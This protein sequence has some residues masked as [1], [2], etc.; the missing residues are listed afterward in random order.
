MI[1]LPSKTQNPQVAFAVLLLYSFLTRL[2]SVKF[3]FNQM[4]TLNQPSAVIC[5]E[6]FS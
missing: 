4:K 5:S 3:G 2:K 6:I 1:I